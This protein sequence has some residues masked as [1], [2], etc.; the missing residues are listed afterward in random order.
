MNSN[1]VDP[2]EVSELG[3]VGGG[4]SGLAC[5]V[6]GVRL[7]LSVTVFEKTD[8]C[9]HK[10]CLAGGRKCNFTHE[11]RPDKM[12]RKFEAGEKLLP[13][14]RRFPYERIVRFFGSLGI[15]SRTDPDGCVWPQGLDAAGVRDRLVQEAVRLG[16]VVRTACKVT[17]LENTGS[18]T[19]DG[20]LQIA[21]VPNHEPLISNPVPW[22][23]VTP[24]GKFACR[25]V[26]VATGGASF[27]QTGSTGDG[28]VLCRRLG[29]Q[30]TDW[31]PALCALRPAQD[32]SRLAGITQRRVGAKLLVD[33]K[34]EMEAEG[35]FVFAHEY[36]SGAAVLVPSGRAARALN[37]GKRV[38][39]QLDWVPETSAEQLG[40][41]F[42]EVRES[43]PRQQL[44]TL[45]ARHVARRLG[46]VICAQAGLQPD[47]MVCELLRA[48]ERQ[49]IGALKGTVFGITGTEPMERATV[50]GGGVVL[51]EV[52]I[53][54]CR[55]RRLPGLYVTGELLDTWA[56]T[57]GYNLHLAWATGIAV[58]EAV[59]GKT[60]G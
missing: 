50:T 55:A 8:R 41:E 42:A 27:P 54:T 46:Q 4:A 37:A 24:E 52:D 59:A 10:L 47:R 17:A 49:A 43:H 26:C 36:I 60:L 13:L 35:P 11:D 12:A 25:N 40:A 53:N 9:G 2:E 22:I 32:L 18:Q 19:V 56:E 34:L 1:L 33:G 28:L 5:A 29:L 39:L 21:E 44:L 14:L 31:F 6:G 16:A 30:T 20:K 38:S 45:L 57:G 15:E 58:A 23:V 3:I 48:E 7:G 51:D